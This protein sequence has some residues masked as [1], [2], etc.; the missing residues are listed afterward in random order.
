[1]IDCQDPELFYSGDSRWEAIVNDLDI[2]R[3]QLPI[4]EK[5]ALELLNYSC[6]KQCQTL[7]LIT[8][9]AGSGKTTLLMRL[10]FNS[11]TNSKFKKINL[12]W[13]DGHEQYEANKI[14]NFYESNLEPI[15]VFIDTPNIYSFIQDMEHAADEISK[16]KA[17]I[18]IIVTARQ[19]EWDNSLGDNK[20]LCSKKALC[21]L[22]VLSDSEI[23]ELLNKLDT[24]KKL[25]VLE[26]LS[27][28]E[29]F[30]N[31]KKHCERQLLV[32]MLEA[33]RGD[34]F[35]NIVLS[36]YKNLKIQHP[37]AA[38]AYEFIS[39]FY[40]YHVSTPKT[41]LLKLLAC[42]DEEDFLNK[43]LK[44]TRLIIVRDFARKFEHYYKARHQEI[45]K[46]LISR[47][48]DYNTEL[49]KLKQV[50]V[51]ITIVDSDERHERYYVLDFLKN[52]IEHIVRTKPAAEYE[53]SINN[54]KSILEKI[55]TRVDHM[56]EEAFRGS[57]IADLV[58][59]SNIFFKLKMWHRYID[60]L[61]KIIGLN[62]TDKRANYRLATA[63]ARSK[64][65]TPE[66]IVECYKNS[67][68]GGNRDIKFLL[69]YVTH[70]VKNGL[71]SHIKPFIDGIDD[72]IVYTQ[73]DNELKEKL[74]AILDGYKIYNDNK[75]LL[76]DTSNLLQN[77][78]ATKGLV[79]R[80]ELD[81]IDL[82]ELSNPLLA[83][84]NCERYLLIIAPNE[85]RSIL[86]RI[87]HI[88]SKIPGKEDIALKYYEKLFRQSQSNIPD[89]FAIT[90]EYFKFCLKNNVKYPKQRYYGIFTALKTMNPNEVGIY[91][92]FAE[93]LVKSEDPADL[94]YCKKII[95]EG[96]KIAVTID[97][98]YIKPTKTLRELKNKLK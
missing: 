60:A 68:I 18:L 55:G 86:I 67:Y 1:M 27:P 12:L 84:E 47:L 3:K 5:E 58:L 83:L 54:L 98:L 72:F 8:G 24:Y 30:E 25:G 9:E 4:I 69:E 20:V 80:D 15:I 17:P 88:A 81:Y 90:Y 87:A 96:L 16:R 57:Y 34:K 23:S 73:E 39:L 19:S 10:A 76:N 70:C 77:I 2:E 37:E 42:F 66:K 61:E 53:D 62:K 11:L 56:I 21:R 6:E 40:M 44:H 46:T 29:R 79:S 43:V 35:E 41:L 48:P 52:Y 64:T 26:K 28:K 63:L 51:M 92:D 22:E 75:K 95:E 13:Y 32:A 97:K 45:A 65:G 59:F 93:Y 89:D 14:L 38:R 71:Y 78:G 82:Y 7:L 91:S 49:N 74:K 85:P 31:F 50:G 36:E 94:K 33:T